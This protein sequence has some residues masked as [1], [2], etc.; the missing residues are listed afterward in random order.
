MALGEVTGWER[1]H[2]TH[3]DEIVEG[4]DRIRWDYPDA[5][6]DDIFAYSGLKQGSEALEIGAGTGIATR[7]FLSRG[8]NVTAV[9]MGVNMVEYIN[10]KFRG[11]ENFCVVNSTF[12][13]AVLDN[14][15]YDLIYA[16]S[17]FH[18]V[19]AEIGC[20]KVF[21]LLK[22]NGTFSL[23]RAY[24]NQPEDTALYSECQAY[25][26]KYYYSHYTSQ[27][28]QPRKTKD[29]LLKPEEIYTGFRFGS[30]EQ[31]GFQ[32]TD[33]KLYDA[34]RDYSADE[35]ISLLDTY[36]D[37]RAL[38]EDNRVSLYAGVKDA[39]LRHGGYQRIDF[40]FMLYMGRKV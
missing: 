10:D 21:T 30:M 8:I 7:P 15:A 11:Y 19:D 38:P 35:Y 34:T 13:D 40:T 16:A 1:N 26:E 9:E 39:I 2:R 28:W 4:Y 14:D 3:F 36:S 17:A 27:K 20:P 32:D 33:I 12:E 23:F 29:D 24:A 31:Y 37:H 22:N 5:L 6:F 25:Y 18:W